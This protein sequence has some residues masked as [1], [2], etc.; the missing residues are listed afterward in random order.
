MCH[1]GNLVND[2]ELRGALTAQGAIFQTSSDTE[3]FLHLYARSKARSVEDAI[4]DS[5]TQLEPDDAGAVVAED[6]VALDRVAAGL[7][8]DLEG[9]ALHAVELRVRALVLHADRVD[10]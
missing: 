2:R 6:G 7:A 9:D 1:N 10:V 4:V 8:P 5:I 3:V